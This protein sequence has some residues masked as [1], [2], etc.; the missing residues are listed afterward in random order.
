MS[1]RIGFVAIIRP[2]FKGDSPAAALDSLEGL[3]R[4]AANNGFEVVLPELPTGPVHAATGSPLPRFAVHDQA[5][6]Q[7]A[8]D[9][10]AAQDLDLLLVQLTTFATGETPAP[11][12]RLPLPLGLWALPEE[13]GA[14]RTT[15]PLPLNSLCG[16]NMTLSFLDRPPVEREM[17][18]K[19]F[20]GSA[21]SD[22]FRE[23]LTPTLTALRGLR[24]L[25]GARIL[26]IGGT[27]PHFYGLEQEPRL[28]G[29]T[30][31]RME[32]TALFERVARVPSA[33]T[34]ELAASWREGSAV[35]EEQLRR[36]AALDLALGRIVSES[37]YDAIALRCWPELPDETGT[38]ACATLARLGDGAV[39]AACEGDVMGALSMLALQGMSGEAALLLDLSDVDPERGALFWHCGNGPLSWSAGATRLAPHFNR[40]GVGTVRDMI[41]R[42][43]PATGFRFTAGAERALLFSGEFRDVTFED[44]GYDGVRGWLSDIRWGKDPVTPRGFVANVLDHRLPHHFA[45]GQSDLT[46]GALEL[47][48]WLGVEVLEPV[49][50]RDTL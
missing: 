31:E 12:L 26:Q 4:L 16:L 48:S 41:V 37:E 18:A 25:R 46:E 35:T 2:I 36:S 47:C 15:G 27:A 28:P 33:A 8:A 21:D 1:L 32:L 5:S 34:E 17:P 39:A 10:L 14:D 42:P 45:F 50:A 40:D 20:Y 38:M 30:V 22:W 6:A 43:G 7:L 24:A 9:Q 13:A 29:V 44:G 11:F 49:P 19:W 23:R 3:E